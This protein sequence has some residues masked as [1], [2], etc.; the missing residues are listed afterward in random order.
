MIG[1]SNRTATASRS[2]DD[3]SGSVLRFGVFE[4][5]FKSCEIRKAGVLLNLPPQPFRILILLARHSGQLVTREEIR[6]EIWGNETFVDFEQGLNFAIRKIRK[7]LGDDPEK[8]RYIETLPRRGYRF[9]PVVQVSNGTQP[10]ML[11]PATQDGSTPPNLES[12]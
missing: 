9:I 2:M 1:F 12:L 10:A 7:T 11:V 8:P 6:K 5:D 4:V 3:A